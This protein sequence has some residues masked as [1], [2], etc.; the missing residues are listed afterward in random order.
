MT[1]LRSVDESA[2]MSRAGRFAVDG[3]HLFLRVNG[4]GSP[5]VVLDSGLGRASDDW[6]DSGILDQ[7][8]SFTQ[9]CAYDR[10]GLG[11]SDPLPTPVPRTAH[12]LAMDLAALLQAA[13]LPPPYIL[14]AH[15]FGGLI[16]RAFAHAHPTETAGL[17]LIDAMHEDDASSVLE[18]LP[19]ASPD[20]SLSLSEYRAVFQETVSLEPEP[21]DWA[22]TTLEM[23]QAG[24]LGAC[25]LVVITAERF[26]LV[27]PDFPADLVTQLAETHQALQQRLVGLSSR[28]TQI[29]AEGSG[30][31][32]TRERPAYIVEA[33]RQITDIVN[34]A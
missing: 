3:Y 20:E 15:S 11:Q 5:T 7:I 14:V 30:H 4:H 21:I 13:Q 28:S 9:V 29:I 16:A 2:D 18:R 33:V 8:A 27:P 25:P 12:A 19:P 1:T 17:V 31:V 22:A 34:S 26:E 32:V 24:S 23:R 6:V 10:A